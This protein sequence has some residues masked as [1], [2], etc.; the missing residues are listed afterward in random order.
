MS[1]KEQIR[2]ISSALGN[3]RNRKN[4]DIKDFYITGIIDSG[5]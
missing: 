5:L 1:S 3:K 2:A 4:S